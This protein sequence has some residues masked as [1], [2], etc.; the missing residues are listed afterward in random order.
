M[1]S[2]LR[3]IR[4]LTWPSDHR[5]GRTRSP[6]SRCTDP[7]LHWIP[8]AEETWRET[9]H[10]WQRTWNM[11]RSD[12]TCDST[13]KEPECICSALLSS[14]TAAAPSAPACRIPTSCSTSS[15]TPSSSSSSPQSGD[16]AWPRV[17]RSWPSDTW[18]V[19]W[20]WRCWPRT[21]QAET[22]QPSRHCT[23]PADHLG[24]LQSVI[25]YY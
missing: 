9:C 1:N 13:L 16:P 19:P 11:W 15:S 2:H 14:W 4:S 18:V 8:G 17:D 5:T 6:G 22:R 12:V 24:P 10:M 20:S 21:R 7:S 23:D 3:H 25:S